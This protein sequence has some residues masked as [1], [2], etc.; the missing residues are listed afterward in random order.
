MKT[1]ICAEELRE[2]GACEEGYRTFIEAHG[3]TTVKFSEALESNGSEDV[4]W[5]L[6]RLELS[7]KRKK[8]LRAFARGQA[9]ICLE[10]IVPYCSPED[11]ATICSWVLDGDE[12]ARSAARSAAWSAA[13]SAVR[14]VALS[15]AN[16]MLQDMVD[17]HTGWA[18]ED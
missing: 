2:L 9:A 3:S 12:S 7:A 6:G 10:K 16:Q 14:G 15:A 1:T 13:D 17:I 5:L 8:D 18:H 11:Y 4:C